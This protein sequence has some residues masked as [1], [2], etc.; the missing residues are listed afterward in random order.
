[1]TYGGFSYK[2]YR[3]AVLWHCTAFHPFLY[4][5]IVWLH[6]LFLLSVQMWNMW[7]VLF[8]CCEALVIQ[9]LTSWQNE[10]TWFVIRITGTSLWCR[11]HQSYAWQVWMA[12]TNL[13]IMRLL[14]IDYCFILYFHTKLQCSVV[15]TQSLFSKTKGWLLWVQIMIYVLLCTL[16]YSISYCVVLHSAIMAPDK[17]GLSRLSVICTLLP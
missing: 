16:Q 6:D 13:E 5:F 7:T 17:T 8:W 14:G 9:W 3:K 4:V 15:I 1:M 2:L 11:L 12:T 10:P